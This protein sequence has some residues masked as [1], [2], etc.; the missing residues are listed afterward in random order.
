[1]ILDCVFCHKIIDSDHLR[2][3]E[4]VEGS[5]PDGKGW[6]RQAYCSLEH[7]LKVKGAQL[8]D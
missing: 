1:M 4:S 2:I 8:H 7:E 6:I 3:G 5:N